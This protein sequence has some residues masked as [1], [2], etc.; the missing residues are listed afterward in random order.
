[1]DQLLLSRLD[2]LSEQLGLVAAVMSRLVPT[3]DKIEDQPPTPA[4]LDKARREDEQKARQPLAQNLQTNLSS[5]PGVGKLMQAVNPL[6]SFF[7]A[8]H[9]SQDQVRSGN[10]RQA[11]L[12][13]RANNPKKPDVLPSPGVPAGAGGPITAGVVHITAQLVNVLSASGQSAGKISESGTIKPSLPPA[14]SAKPAE[15][16]EGV[17]VEAGVVAGSTALAVGAAVAAVGVAALKAVGAL[18]DFAKAARGYVEAFA[19][20]LVIRYDQAVRD[21]TAAIGSGLTPVVQTATNVLRSIAST[22]LPVMDRLRPVLQT[23]GDLFLQLTTAILDSVSPMLDALTALGQIFASVADVL[24]TLF[25]PVLS[26]VSL[27]LTSVAGTLRL[28][29]PVV[30]LLG[31]ALKV[32][33]MPMTWLADAFTVLVRVT[34]AWGRWLASLFE[35]FG[36]T[37][38]VASWADSLRSAFQELLKATVALSARLLMMFGATGLVQKMADAFKPKPSADG[39]A[40]MQDARF[41]SFADFSKQAQLAAATALGGADPQKTGDEWLRDIHKQL[42]EILEDDDQSFFDSL[43]KMLEDVTVKVVSSEIAKAAG[44]AAWG[45]TLPGLVANSLSGGNE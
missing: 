26:F 17:G 18:D 23:F 21:L 33:L 1:M 37:K 29:T 10:Q 38:S 13:E 28:L 2:K 36:W 5:L 32:V 6:L 43:R 14:S 7:D 42:E 11:D 9:R 16:A 25:R 45:L 12:A 41:S 27:L 20:G 34:E 31:A 30:E 40:A 15:A 8:F 44:K 35:G 19:P 4:D 24:L 39:L 3:I 22:L